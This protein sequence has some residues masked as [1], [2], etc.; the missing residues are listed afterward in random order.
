MATTET[1]LAVY[2]DG[3]ITR[4]IGI[5]RDGVRRRG[6]GKLDEIETT[7]VQFGERAS[8]KYRPARAATRWC[9]TLLHAAFCGSWRWV[10]AASDPVLAGAI[11]P[12]YPAAGWV[13][14][15]STR[16]PTPTAFAPASLRLLARLTAG[17]RVCRDKPARCERVQVSDSEG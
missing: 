4:S 12:G 13:T 5:A 1:V 14:T 3:A 6:T 15:G 11:P 9:P 16:K 10:T 17:V 8:E 7:H 2:S